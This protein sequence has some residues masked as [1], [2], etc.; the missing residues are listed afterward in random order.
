MDPAN[1]QRGPGELVGN[2]EPITDGNFPGGYDEPPTPRE[3][4]PPLEGFALLSAGDRTGATGTYYVFGEVRNDT[5]V[6]AESVKIIVTLYDAT[7]TVVR[8]SPTWVCRCASGRK[9]ADGG[10]PATSRAATPSTGLPPLA[11][12]TTSSASSA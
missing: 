12:A 11:A 9:A 7:G 6:E 1:P 2:G 5:G 8:S 3:T 4:E 10:C